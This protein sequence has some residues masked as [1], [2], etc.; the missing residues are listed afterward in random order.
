MPLTSSNQHQNIIY[1]KEILRDF[2]ALKETSQRT[3]LKEEVE[4]LAGRLVDLQASLAS[5]SSGLRD[6]MAKSQQEAAKCQQ[7][8]TKAQQ[9]AAKTQQEA[10]AHFT[11]Q[12]EYAAKNAE[13]QVGKENLT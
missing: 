8:A 5:Q 2:A 9:E 7:A 12:I 6:E 4:G 3:E 1:F 13:K 10:A 11:S